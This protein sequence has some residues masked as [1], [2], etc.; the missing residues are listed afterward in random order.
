MQTRDAYVPVWYAGTV[1]RPVNLGS[2]LRQSLASNIT[3]SAAKPR[4]TG[5]NNWGSGSFGGGSVGGGGGGGR[6]GGW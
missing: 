5:G 4:S 2:N 6:T 1:L 3:Q